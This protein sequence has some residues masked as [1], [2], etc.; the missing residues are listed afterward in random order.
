[1]ICDAVWAAAGCGDATRATRAMPI[2]TQ[3]A[4]AQH[5]DTAQAGDLRFKSMMR[6]TV[7]QNCNPFVR[8]IAGRKWQG[9][10]IEVLKVQPRHSESFLIFAIRARKRRV[11]STRHRAPLCRIRS[12]PGRPAHRRR[13]HGPAATEE[14]RVA[15][16]FTS[17]AD[18]LL[19]S[20]ERYALC[21]PLSARP[22][23]WRG[24]NM[25]SK[26]RQRHRAARQ[27]HAQ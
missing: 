7:P 10:A 12:R 25:V 16:A 24:D 14:I 3:A 20:K 15:A 26:H 2:N 27:G 1:V 18:Q 23:A 5:K 4:G 22:H 11:I 19:P 17:H 6:P 13:E 21:R 9:A 8:R